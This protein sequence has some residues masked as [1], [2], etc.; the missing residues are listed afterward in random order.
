[1]EI[2]LIEI[3]NKATCVPA[4]VTRLSSTG[5]AAGDWL[6]RHAGYDLEY[7]SIMLTRLT[8]GEGQYDPYRWTNRTMRGAHL[9]LM[10]HFDEVT[11]GDV[12]E[13]IPGERAAPK[14]SERIELYTR[15]PNA[16]TPRVIPE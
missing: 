3:R 15:H 8:N 14:G 11:M 5:D 12:V 10:E 4:M 2:K 6:L 16:S 7:P 9:W 13:F 1:M